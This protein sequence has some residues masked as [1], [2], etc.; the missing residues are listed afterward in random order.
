MDE[1]QHLI[2]KFLLRRFSDDDKIV[3]W[4]RQLRK[5]IPTSVDRAAR[6]GSYYSV[7]EEPTVP[8]EGLEEALQS[9][10]SVPGLRDSIL[11]V[12]ED[13]TTTLKRNAIEAFLS[14]MEGKA[15]PAVQR[16][17]NDGPPAAGRE[18][19][20]DR[21]YIAALVALQHVR[22]ESFREQFD[23]VTRTFIRFQMENSTDTVEADLDGLDSLQIGTSHKLAM[24]LTMAIENIAPILFTATWRVLHYARPEVVGSDEGVGL[25][26]RPSRDL[27]ERPLA[28]GTADAIYVPLGAHDILQLT[29]SS[30]KEELVPGGDA[31]LR[32]SNEAVASAAQRWIFTHPDNSAVHDLGVRP[33]R[34]VRRELFP[35]PSLPSGARHELLRFSNTL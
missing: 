28:I 18:R 33:R 14:H 5:S 8:D 3:V 31:K 22:G 9:L 20:V 17:A 23:E 30:L 35:L 19:E 16:L 34:R 32:Q 29:N 12:K 24:M 6:I 7:P 13:G 4:D 1:K 11:E 26:A 25:W 21:F 2:P 27:D 10:S 15:A